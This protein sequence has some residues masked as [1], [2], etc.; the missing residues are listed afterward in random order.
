MEP[1]KKR[2]QSCGM[3]LNQGWYGTEKDGTQNTTYCS[4]CY[5]N[6]AFTD[7]ERTLQEMLEISIEHMM[8]ELHFTREK[9]TEL[10]HAVIPN[11]GRWKRNRPQKPHDLENT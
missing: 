11:L 4:F 5:K 3:P 2:C 8:K 9:A 7:P 6:G 1:E 10:A